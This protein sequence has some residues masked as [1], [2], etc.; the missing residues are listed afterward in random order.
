M[1]YF[2]VFIML[3]GL[4]T[5]CQ[6]EKPTS[7][8]I[9]QPQIPIL[10]A[11]LSYVN[12]VED[13][14]AYYT[15][16]GD[17]IDPY[18]YF[19]ERG[20]NV[21]RLRLWNAP[22]HSPYSN[23]KD[24]KKSIRRAHEAGVAV[25]L[26][27]HYSDFW[28]DPHKQVRPKAWAG[29]TDDRILAD[30]IYNYTFE[31]LVSLAEENLLP[32]W[33]QVGNETNIEILQPLDTII[34][35][36]INW[37]RNAMLLNSG[38]KAVSDAEKAFASEIKSVL[39]IAQPENALNWFRKAEEYRVTDFDIIGLSYYSKWSTYPIEELSIA[40]DSLKTRFKKEVVI[41]ET[42]YPHSLNNADAAGNILGEDALI[43]GYTA[44]P[45]GQ[46]NYMLQLTQNVLDAGGL[47]V[48]YWEP[49]WVTSSCSTPWGT[50]SHW[51]NATF[52]DA[53]Q[54]NGALPVF[55]FFDAKNYSIPTE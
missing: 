43:E 47:G 38:L 32:Q 37:S 33:V 4:I 5:A 45:E 10:G 26:D 34:T 18:S 27:F 50:G 29:I 25:L 40:I 22:E 54:S 30:S 49:A 3:L 24:V 1:N 7:K 16:E 28:A 31:T 11:D 53:S 2:R 6:S 15:A 51:D 20:A 52:F 46:K 42:A 41:V 35:D 55:E 9:A 36:T 8:T 39:H 23:F 21:I 13:C 44:T 14:G 17:T 48:I 19:A 12:E